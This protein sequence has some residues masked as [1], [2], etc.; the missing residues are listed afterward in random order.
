MSS[1]TANDRPKIKDRNAGQLHSEALM[2]KARAGLTDPSVPPSQEALRAAIAAQMCPWCDKGPFKMLPVHTNKVHGID[3]WDLRDYAGYSTSDPLCS[4]E[5]RAAMSRAY[6]PEKG[7][8]AREAARKKWTGQRRTQRWTRAGLAKNAA[9][10][11]RY[12]DETPVDVRADN[13]RKASAL[14]DP[15]VRQAA[16]KRA[17]EAKTDEQ[18]AAFIAASQRPESVAKRS[19]ALRKPPPPHGNLNRYKHHG[20]RCEPCREAKAQDRIMAKERRGS[21]P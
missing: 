4:E 21:T 7:R 10:I 18:R 20:C 6:D 2:R 15:E 16:G 5:A 1:R 9:T 17:W 8:E 14:T 3:K 11:K 13:A 12:N 19:A